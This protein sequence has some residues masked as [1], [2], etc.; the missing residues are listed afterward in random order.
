MLTHAIQGVL[1][2]IGML[3]LAIGIYGMPGGIGT[4]HEAAAD[5]THEQLIGM[6]WI[7]DTVLP[8]FT[9]LT[10]MPET[11]S[12]AFMFLLILVFAV[13]IGVLAQ[14]QL[15][16]RYLSAKD[17]KSLR[18]AIPY[19]GIFILLMTFI[20]FSI[21]P[22]CNV[23][24]IN[25]GLTYPGTPDKVVPLIVNKLFSPWFVLLFLSAILSAAMSTT[26]A[27]FHTAGASIGRDVYEKGLMKVC[28][29]KKSILIT[30]IATLLIII[31]TLILSLYPSG[32]VAVLTSFFLW[33]D[34]LHF[35]CTLHPHALLEKNQ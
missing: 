31:A 13:G 34:G 22:L 6:G 29:D 32:V 35:S 15:I 28:T 9:T 30:R 3:L 18:R 4:A 19:G 10:S 5:L 17:E 16:I 21:D 14:P 11:F 1:M 7:K 27:L 24:M 25:Y 20:A 8:S 26:R 12:P 2:L 33:I 23:L